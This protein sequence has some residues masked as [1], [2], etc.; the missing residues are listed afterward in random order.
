[1]IIFLESPILGK[2]R[3]LLWNIL[4]DISVLIQ[5]PFKIKKTYVPPTSW[6]IGPGEQH[7]HP[8]GPNKE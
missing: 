6:E 2:L 1:M 3:S 7:L 5:M 8:T 4:K